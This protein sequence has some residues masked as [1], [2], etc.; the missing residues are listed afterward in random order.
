MPRSI[1]AVVS[2][3]LATLVDCDTTLSLQD[4]YDLLE[5]MAIDAHNQNEQT[6]RAQQ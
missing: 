3:K 6:K 1:G 5:I 2:G 4:V